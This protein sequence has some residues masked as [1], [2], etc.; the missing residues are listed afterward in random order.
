VS[1]CV[2]AVIGIAATQPVELP[3]GLDPTIAKLSQEIEQEV[4]KCPAAPDDG[5]ECR[6][7]HRSGEIT[8]AITGTEDREDTIQSRAV[9]VAFIPRQNSRE[10]T[11]TKSFCSSVVGHGL[12][13]EKPYINKP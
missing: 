7:A 9:C 6:P 10:A 5:S 4:E 12:R 1:V 8:L 11:V 2:D 3:D 13:S